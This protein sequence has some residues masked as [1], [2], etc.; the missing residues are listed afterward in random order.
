MAIEL[1]HVAERLEGLLPLPAQRS[2]ERA[3]GE[4]FVSSGPE[5]A[6]SPRPSPPLRKGEGEGWSSLSVFTTRPD[7]L[8]GAT[9]MVLAPEHPLTPL[10]ASPA[11]AQAVSA[12]CQFAASKSDLER[13]D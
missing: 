10:L 1:S 8:F 12:Y 6:S 2:G 7:T 5:S 4:G 3:G 11:Q 13:T 9:Y